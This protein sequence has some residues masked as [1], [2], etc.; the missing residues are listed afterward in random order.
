MRGVVPHPLTALL[1]SLP[2]CHPASLAFPALLC[3]RFHRYLPP[4][5]TLPLSFS[6][7]HAHKPCHP[8]RSQH[9]D[10]SSALLQLLYHPGRPHLL[11]HTRTTTT[12]VF[13]TLTTPSHSCYP[14]DN[15]T[16]PS[17]L[18]ALQHNSASHALNTYSPHAIKGLQLDRETMITA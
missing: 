5:P 11:F 16:A 17:S 8:L 6:R 15:L 1:P 4:L 3:F 7:P 12:T 2:P 10:H 9:F 13:S 18:P 14:H